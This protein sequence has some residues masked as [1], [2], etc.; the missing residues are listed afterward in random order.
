V[1]T[2]A[3]LSVLAAVVFLGGLRLWV[4]Q[5]CRDR[6]YG[7]LQD[8]PPRPT[9]IVLGAGLRPDGSITPILAER[10]ATAADLYHAGAAEV[11]LLSGARRPGYDEPGVMRDYAVRLGVPREATLLDPKGVRT[12]ATCR[13]AREV[14]DVE[15]AVVVTQRFHT[16]RSLYLC[17]AV[18]IDAVAIAAGG[19]KPGS[20]FLRRRIVWE[21][22]EYLA[23]VRAVWDVNFGRVGPDDSP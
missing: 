22:R 12:Y 5:K 16:A 4:E 21:T 10:V 20:L 6:V 1:L 18:G 14:F 17:D 19:K 11:L 9:A 3:L 23:L 7:S 15:R 13:R 2:A 8:V